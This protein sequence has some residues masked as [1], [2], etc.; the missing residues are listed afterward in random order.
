VENQAITTAAP[1]GPSFRPIL[2]AMCF[3]S[4]HET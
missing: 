2:W 1:V 4:V 3:S